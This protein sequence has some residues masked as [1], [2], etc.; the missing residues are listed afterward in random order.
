M[1]DLLR[2]C[3]PQGWVVLDNKFYDVEPEADEDGDFI[4]NWHEGFVEDVLWIQ[5]C[6]TDAQGGYRLP[7]HLFFS[8]D[9]S[10]LPDSRI[11]GSYYAKL[12]RCEGED[13]I[14]IELF[15]S[16]NRFEVRARIEFWLNNL[17]H[18][19]S[20]YRTDARRAQ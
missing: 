8:I 19:N 3:I 6:R 11:D 20:A 17:Q 14:E 2:I 9:L 4:R 16:T 10:W 7:E 12:S 5:E 13:T 1:A 18:P 15:E